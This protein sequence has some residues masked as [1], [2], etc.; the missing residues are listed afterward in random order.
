MFIKDVIILSLEASEYDDGSNLNFLSYRIH[1]L[2]Y[3]RFQK[4]EH[5]VS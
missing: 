1:G 3:P 2:K 4:F 5:V